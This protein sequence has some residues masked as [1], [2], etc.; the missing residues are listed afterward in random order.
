[1]PKTLLFASYEESFWSKRTRLVSQN[2]YVRGVHARH[3]TLKGKE[4]FN[5]FWIGLDEGVRLG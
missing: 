1:M 5:M 2:I 4:E 3:L